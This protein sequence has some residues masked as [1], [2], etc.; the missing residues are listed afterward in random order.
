MSATKISYLI[1]TD[2]YLNYQPN[3]VF[4]NPRR[5]RSNG[6]IFTNPNLRISNL[7]SLL[8][9]QIKSRGSIKL[10]RR[11]VN[12]SK[13]DSDR[14][15]VETDS[16]MDCVGTGYN[17][18]CVVD[19]TSEETD[20]F[21]QKKIESFEIEEKDGNSEL[22]FVKGVLEWG[23]LISPFFFWGT[24][25][26]AMKEVFPK[27]GPFFVSAFRLIPAGFMLV[28]FAGLRGRK[29]PSGVMAWVSIVLFGLVDA[30]CFQGFLAEGLQRTSAGLGS[31]IIDS[32]P[33][34]VAILA[35][36]LF[37][38][39]IGVV[40]AA[41]LVLGVVG[42]LLLELPALSLEGSNSSLWGSGEWWML[43]AAQSMAVGTV[44]VRWVSKYSDPIMATGWHMV[45]GG[46]P[47][48][49]ISILNHDPAISGGL[50]ELNTNDILALIY[51]SIFGSAIS[52]GVYFYNASRGSLT[53]LSSLTFL[54]PMFASIFGFLYLGETFSELQLFGALVTVVAI[55]MV[56]YRTG[57]NNTIE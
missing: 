35:S 13:S 54:T 31:V 34:T 24:A 4:V 37:G 32:Q 17:V 2:S 30:A 25:M 21:L 9:T 29:Q 39:S 41:G 45:I 11:T 26:V 7:S 14:E 43:L 57:T 28:A 52:Y 22:G 56:N 3:H 51:T 5:R 15:M 16:S 50:K 18:E 10:P 33:L 40:G 49:A 36:L 44:M 19:E 47:L 23:L 8:N 46:V 53:K 1:Q 38:E 42:L 20:R 6:F 12:C 48:L 55:Y 27:A